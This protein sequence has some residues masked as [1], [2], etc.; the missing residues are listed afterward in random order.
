MNK[1]AKTEVVSIPAVSGE[2][3]FC[4]CKGLLSVLSWEAAHAGI[5]DKWMPAGV[6]RARSRFRGGFCVSFVDAGK[7]DTRTFST[8]AVTWVMSALHDMP[9]PVHTGHYLA[10][11]VGGH[12]AAEPLWL[13]SARPRPALQ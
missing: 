11:K 5:E 3:V 4:A 7:L 9:L 2:K 13:D 8:G 1:P 12:G 10:R 6:P